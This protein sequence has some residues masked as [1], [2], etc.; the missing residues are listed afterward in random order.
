MRKGQT[1]RQASGDE[2]NGKGRVG[3]ERASFQ[4]LPNGECA[5]GKLEQSPY[6]SHW[7]AHQDW[8]AVERPDHQPAP[9]LSE[10]ARRILNRFSLTPA[11]RRALREADRGNERY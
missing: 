7:A 8:A 3:H 6:E 4:S 10:D 1:K 11:A 5:A 9:L 2:S